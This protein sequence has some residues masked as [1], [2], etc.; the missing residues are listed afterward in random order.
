MKPS[1][2]LLLVAGLLVMALL[3]SNLQGQVTFPGPELL[4]RPTSSSVTINVVASAAIQAYFEYGA[5]SGGE[6]QTSSTSGTAASPLSAAA[7][8]P[9]VAVIGGLN[10]DTQYYYYMVYRQS[11]TSAWTTRP[12]HS[13]HTARIPGDTFTFTVTSDSHINIEF[14]NPSLFQQTLRNIAGESPDFHLDLGDTFAMDNG[15]IQPCTNVTT[16]AQANSS[17]LNIRTN[18]FSLISA[19]VPI[20]LALGNHE[21]EEGWHLGDAGFAVEPPIMSANARNEYFLNPDPLLSSFYTGNTDTSYSGIT[22]SSDHT[23]QDYYA[24][25]WGDA[26]FVVIDPYWYST[27][28]PY[29]GNEGGGESSTPGS[30]NRWDWT[31]GLMQYLWL[32]QTLQ[33]STAKYKFI[34]AHQVA[35]GL[36]DYGRGGAYAV[37]YVEWGGNNDDGVSWAFDTNRTD[38]NPEWITP[39]HQLLVANHVTAFFHGHD[40]EY[41]HEQRDGVVYQEVPMA[42]DATYGYGFQEYKADG[43]YTLK[44]LPNSGHLRVTV[45]P[46][47]GV[48]VQYVRASLAAAGGTN[49]AIA[50]SYNIPA[51]TTS[52]SPSVSSLTM[53]PTTLVG[54]G[55]SFSTGTVTLSGPVPSTSSA[56]QV[57]LTSSNPSAAT[58]PSQ[59]ISI[60]AGSATG[61]FAA[62]SQV[63]TSS[64]AST[65]ITAAAI[66]SGSA[67][68]ILT[69][70]P[71]ATGL[72]SLTL[73]PTSVV[74]GAAN[75]TSTGT[76]TLNG[77]APTAGTSVALS[78]SNTSAAIVP[79]SVAVP[80]NTTSNTFQISSN[81]VASSTPVTIT[82]SLNGS[83][84]ATLTVN[85]VPAFTPV[86]I[87]SGGP[88]YTDSLGQKWTADT[89]YTGGNTY[90]TTNTIT[91][92]SDPTLYKT[93]RYGASFSYA[94]SAP[95][96]AYSVTLKF[97]EP[98]WSAV[99]K[100]VFNVAI[101]GTTVLS[102]F[103]I[104]AA[105]GAEFKAVDETF[106]VTVTSS[107]TIT[108][109]FTAGSAGNP[110]VNAIQVVAAQ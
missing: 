61:T 56:I 24:W 36:D 101:N 41:A 33:S 104:F 21:Q 26:L 51:P 92:T 68:A 11:S 46:I 50:D 98:V 105:A 54:D 82:A 25:T 9:L 20:F 39:V 53:N 64:A 43:V 72:T 42:A 83:K 58:V 78:S 18:Y 107:G 45:D 80:Y 13:F 71:V 63:V 70:N 6:N 49:E 37:P 30:G 99:G 65:S 32:E 14:G 102:K 97:A 60:P 8:Q 94:I 88:A 62:T 86:R 76:V 48:T 75:S 106:P 16:Q 23:I 29:V 66:G 31:L 84:T 47:N 5:Q 103:D 69:V 7:N 100:R 40:H 93:S 38:M 110:L 96:G 79:T 55:S 12:E 22:S 2:A 15:C 17:Y 28:K 87:N 44:V 89:G 35:G 108:I 10:S 73:N 3:P 109:K 74:G 95:A 77:S 57:T 1:K 34:F 27:T 59:P 19:S 91:N 81:S 67:Q 52:G 85:P 4:G 90:S